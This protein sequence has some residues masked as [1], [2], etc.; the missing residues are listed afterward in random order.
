MKKLTVVLLALLMIC[1]CVVVSS[2]DYQVCL[3]NQKMTVDLKPVDC[4]AYNIDGY[5]YFRLR[6]LAYLLRETDCRF[7]VDYDSTDNAVLI[8]TGDSYST[9]EKSP[10]RDGSDSA[11]IS[12]Q[13][14]IIDGK[15]VEGLSAF[16]IDGSNYFKLADLQKY[17]NYDLSYDEVSRTV[18][19]RAS[20]NTI[21][22]WN[23]AD[24]AEV[25]AALKKAINSNRGGYSSGAGV[26]TDEAIAEPAAA[27]KDAGTSEKPAPAEA[28]NTVSEDASSDEEY[29]GTNVQVEGIDEGDIVKTDGRYIYVLHGNNELMILEAKGP[30]TEI[31]SRTQ[32][33]YYES[34]YPEKETMDY[35]YSGEYKTPEEMYV[36]NG[37]LAVISNYS[38]YC[39][40]KAD[41]EWHYEDENYSCIDI[42]DVSD[43]RNPVLINSFG[44]DGYTFDSRMAEG[45]LYLATR[46]WVWNYDENDP[47]TYIPVI[48]NKGME[49]LIA[50]DSIYISPDC[51][52]PE[53]VVLCSYDLDTVSNTDAKSLLGCGDLLYMNDS[54]IYVLGTKW[55]NEASPSYHESVYTVT[56][57]TSGASTEIYRF[58]LCNGALS[59]AAS[60]SVK[61]NLESQFSADE[62]NGYLRLVTTRSED[63]YYVY[64]DETY[65]FSNYKWDKDNTSNSLYVLDENLN[66]VGCVEDLAEDEFVYSA[67]YDGDFVYFCTYRNTDPLFAVD[68]SNP[69]APKVLSALK[70][71]GFSEYLHNWGENKLFGFGRETNE[72]TG[73]SE[74]LKL[75]MFDTTDK[76]DVKVENYL[77]LDC[78]YSEALYNH[79][80]FFIDP[81]KNIIGFLGN[82]DYYVFSYDTDNGFHELCHVYFDTWEWNVRGLWIGNW[83]YVVGN[84]ELLVFNMKNWSEVE[85]ISIM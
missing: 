76:T 63:S 40:W 7:S 6:E 31:V 3:S 34:Q 62:Y 55:K 67:R 41:G 74:G 12:S 5:N 72:E 37:H 51:T 60:G 57:Y 70:I 27:E 25:N 54:N 58:S 15:T 61:G 4:T 16:N 8:T 22:V 21:R 43:P 53:Y 44:Q 65:G 48:Y 13:K 28:T 46:Y 42:Y 78:T 1:S 84:E 45:I 47:G 36:F 69:T 50:A 79:K 38:S 14:V 39:E 11:V 77:V 81:E 35:V 10:E 80:A 68:L 71:S 33:G 73:W 24:Y 9:P 26:L 23:T 2:A 30:D 59:F 64:Q 85:P 29:S 82:D 49:E 32:A 17:L 56:H 75:V 83:A 20:W 18:E 66:C 19:I 52:S